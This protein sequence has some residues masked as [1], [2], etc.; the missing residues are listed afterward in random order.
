VSRADLPVPLGDLIA[1]WRSEAELLRR[2]GDERGAHVCGL[3]AE[4][5]EQAAAALAD[6]PLTL[7]AAAAESGYSERRLRELLAEGAIPNAGRR[8]AP[9]IR[10]G[11]L[12]RK[13]GATHVDSAYD[14]AAD[15]RSLLS[16]L[17]HAS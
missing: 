3:H 7:A 1:R 14:P 2:Y 10:R 15:A 16:R 6:E 9:R 8:H 17:P 4:E 11:D 5:L 13:P 12:P